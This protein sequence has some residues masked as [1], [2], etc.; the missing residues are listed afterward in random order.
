MKAF[1]GFNVV[2]KGLASEVRVPEFELLYGL[3]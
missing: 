3:G 1:D 2:V